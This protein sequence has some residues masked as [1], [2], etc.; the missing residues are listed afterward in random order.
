MCHPPARLSCLQGTTRAAPSALK[1]LSVLPVHHPRKGGSL[2]L[3]IPLS[4]FKDLSSSLVDCMLL[5]LARNCR[6][7][8]LCNLLSMFLG[9]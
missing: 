7:T 4:L 5:Y 9:E 1:S 3:N 2:I 6:N 8:K